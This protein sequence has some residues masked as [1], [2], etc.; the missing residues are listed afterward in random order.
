MQRCLVLKALQK[1]QRGLGP[2][3]AGG[4]LNGRMTISTCASASGRPEDIKLV[5]LQKDL[6]PHDLPQVA[7]CCSKLQHVQVSCADG[8]SIWQ[9]YV[10]T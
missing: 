4:E 8:A 6:Q 1:G 2:D 9:H 10:C 5:V 3:S 7:E